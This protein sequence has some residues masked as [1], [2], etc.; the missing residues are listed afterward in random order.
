[1]PNFA[2]TKSNATPRSRMAES[3]V[4]D[5]DIGGGVLACAE[6]GVCCGA[7]WFVALVGIGETEMA[8]VP[9]LVIR[10]GV[11]VELLSLV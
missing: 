1:M 5:N 3:D 11:V 8:A 7:A 6:V 4:C 9:P 2:L 10:C